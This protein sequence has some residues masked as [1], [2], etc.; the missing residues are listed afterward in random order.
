MNLVSCALSCRAAVA[1]FRKAGKGGH[2]VNIS[3]RPALNPRQGASMTAYTASKAAVAAFTVALA[4]ELKGENISV[5]ALAP[6]TIDTPTNRK[7]MPKADH[8]SWVKP[9]RDR[10]ADRGASRPQ[11]DDQLRRADPGLRQG[12]RRGS[13]GPV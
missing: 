12:V 1:N 10:R 6:S 11:R 3:A 9:S 5:I 7:D 13:T 4:E 2:I 8:A